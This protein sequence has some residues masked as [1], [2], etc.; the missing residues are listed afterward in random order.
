MDAVRSTLLFAKGVVLVEGDAE[1]IMIPAM[2]RSVFG[3][4]PD[5]LGFSVI[6]MSSSFFEHVALIFAEDRVQRPCAIVT[7]LDKPIVDLPSDPNDD[8]RTDAASRAAQKSGEERREK[9][10]AFTS[11]NKWVKTF[12]AEYTFEVD[13]IGAN[14]SRE[15]VYTLDSIYKDATTKAEVRSRL[16]SGDLAICGAE[17]LRLAKKYGKGWFALLLSEKLGTWTYIPEYIMRALAFACARSISLA[18]LKRMGEFRVARHKSDGLKVLADLPKFSSVKP[19]E[20]L[21]QYRKADPTDALSLFCKFI[22][23][24]K[25]T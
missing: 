6:S 22:S 5:E 20:F 15:V 14:N 17:A 11:G 7:D 21:E 4:S 10:D 16:E 12:F 1:Q 24:Y 23:E 18:A 3:V 8:S 9:L 19:R 2:L 13:F 25:T